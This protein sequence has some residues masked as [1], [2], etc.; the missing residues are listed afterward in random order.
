MTRRR[1]DD[2]G[3]P[4]R[5]ARD[6][7]SV[8]GQG[9]GEGDTRSHRTGR[10]CCV[11]PSV[12]CGPDG[13]GC[14]RPASPQTT[15]ISSNRGGDPMTADPTIA[16]QTVV[17]CARPHHSAAAGFVALLDRPSAGSA[18]DVPDWSTSPRSHG[19]GSSSQPRRR[20]ECHRQRQ[21]GSRT[22][23]RDPIRSRRR[24]RVPPL[25]RLPLPATCTG[26]D[27]RRS[28]PSTR[29]GDPCRSKRSCRRVGRSAMSTPSNHPMTTAAPSDQPARAA[30]PARRS[31]G[32]QSADINGVSGATVTS[33]AMAV[34]AVDPRWCGG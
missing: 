27:S 9:V 33:S 21:V 2:P 18:T 23:R 30:D 29:G 4:D 16:R 32:R 24:R 12:C 31:D 26:H 8:L 20:P 7:R 22:A 3:R 14:A 11:A 1:T 17:A 5:D 28:R 13:P 25:N 10:A 6:E 15:S 19:G 34:A